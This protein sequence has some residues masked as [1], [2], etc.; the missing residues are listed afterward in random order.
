MNI[1]TETRLP[2]EIYDE[3]FVPALFAQWGKVVAEAAR[4]A[5]GQA[6]LDVA[7]GTGA[8]TVSAAAMAGPGGRVVG[9]DASPEMLA[10]ARRKSSDIDWRQAAAEELPFDEASFDAVVSQF[11]LMFFKDR[12]L[13][14]AEMMRVLRPGGHLAVA[15]CG[16]VEH[17]PGYAAFALLLDELFG[18]AVGNAFR[19]PFVLGDAAELARIATAAGIEEAS[20]EMRKGTV[21]FP[22][23]E[24]MVATEGACVWTLGG[25]LDAGQ[26]ALLQ[27]KAQEALQPFVAADGTVSFDMPALI[28]TTRKEN[29]AH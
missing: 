13:A 15:V 10:V 5:P 4:L 23:I 21:R 9:L 27:R 19:A 20:L 14:L 22:S 29:G 2:A 25:I 17:S 26:L 8:L 24:D 6:V 3:R 7:C 16:A 12:E 28:L 11:G 18:E 1:R